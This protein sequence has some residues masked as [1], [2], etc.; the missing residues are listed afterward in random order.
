MK[1]I[2]L[3]LLTF[4]AVSVN[5]QYCQVNIDCTDDDLIN[6]VEFSNLVNPSSCSLN[7]YGD[8]TTTVEPAEVTAGETY[9]LLVSVGSGWFERV[10]L[11]ID[12]NNDGT[13][14]TADFIGEVGEG[15][16]GVELTEDIT[17]PAD[18]PTGSYRMRLLAMAVG[19]DNPASEDPCINESTQYGEYEDYMINVTNN[20]M[21][22]SDVDAA[23]VS[24]Y[25][26]PVKD[27]FKLNLSSIYNS[28]KT[29]VTVTDLTGKKV[30]TFAAGEAYNVS[31][32]AKGVYILTVTDGA[33]QFTQKLIK[34]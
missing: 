30:K 10:S 23:K 22:V 12:F 32:L 28:A 24:V 14:D 13:F 33:N 27:E 31:D 5:A 16:S 3:S 19:S 17:I 29:Q 20:T 1:K 11:W 2:L 21:S 18:T 7:G 25:P 26:N 9:P 8:Y 6:L 34:K 4:G 15:G